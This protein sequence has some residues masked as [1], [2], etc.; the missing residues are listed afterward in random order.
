MRILYDSKNE[1]YKKPFGCVHAGER[2][3]MSVY[4][5][6]SVCTLSASVFLEDDDGTKAEHALSKSGEEDLYD[7]YSVSFCIDAEGLYFYYFRICAECSSFN[8]FK[9]NYSDTNMEAGDKWQ[10]TVVPKCYKTPSCFKGNV[11]YQIFPDRFAQSGTPDLSKKLTPFWIHE[12]KS[13]TPAFLPDDTGEVTNCDFYGGNLRGIEEKL[14]YIKEL[15]VTT[16][17]LNPIFKAFSNHRYDTYDY[18]TVDPMLGTYDDFVSLCKS[19]KK[20]GI[21]IIL[22]GVFSH[23][24]IRSLYFEDAQRNPDSPFR[25]WY[26][27]E[28]YPDKYTSWWGIK[29]LPDVMETEPSYIEYIITGCDSV[30]EHWLRAG[31]SGFRLDVA[32]ELPDEFIAL[33]RKRMKEIDPEAILLGEV[34]E[35]ASNKISY[36]VRRKY[37]TGGELDSVMNYP[38]M[39]AIIDFVSEKID[40]QKF[41]EIIMTI[42]ENYPREALNCLMNSLSTHDTPRVLTRLCGICPESREERANTVFSGEILEDAIK[43]LKTAAFLQYILPGN[44]CIYY[45]DEIGMQGF[46]DPFCRRYYDFENKNADLLS[47]FK[48]LG[49]LKN[50]YEELRAGSTK[51]YA[52]DSDTVIIERGSLTAQVNR[53]GEVCKC[54]NALFLQNGCALYK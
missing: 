36:S 4:I 50:K 43:K 20:L 42:A 23:T 5:P 35:D 3:R 25:K 10:L 54:E 44:P 40:A 14:T 52:K 51:V 18:K 46:E 28:S 15:G 12:N 6:K 26:K 34:W 1:K 32:D 37:F 21:K 45:G 38:F 41:T 39:N 22:D 2:I 19:A 16:I 29:T 31:A 24:G 33:L 13:D 11:M 7:I 49:S 53:S 48:K 30:I 27:F 17:Y 47:L 9:Q 8:L